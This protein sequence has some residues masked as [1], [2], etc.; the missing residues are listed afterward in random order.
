[1]AKNRGTILREHLGRYLEQLLLD[2]SPTELNHLRRY[3]RKMHW[4]AIKSR[5]EE[6]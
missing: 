4:E 3:I 6:E 2:S 5:G 1:M